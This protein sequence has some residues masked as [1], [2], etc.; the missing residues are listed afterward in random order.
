M[1]IIQKI[2]NCID[3]IESLVSLKKAFIYSPYLV[4]ACKPCIA[5]AFAIY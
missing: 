2:T 5:I 3:D 4:K 1:L